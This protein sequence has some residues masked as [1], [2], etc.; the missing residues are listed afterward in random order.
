METGGGMPGK[1]IQDVVNAG[2]E[3]K[4]LD[5]LLAEEGQVDDAKTGGIFTLHGN[6]LIACRRVV[7]AAAIAGILELQ[8]GKDFVSYQRHGEVQFEEIVGRIRHIPARRIIPG[9]LKRIA[10]PAANAAGPECFQGQFHAFGLRV[11]VGEAPAV[12]DDQIVHLVVE[13]GEGSSQMPPDVLDRK[14][15]RLNSSHANISYA[16]FC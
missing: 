14:S 1:A 7:E 10:R 16:V 4:V 11:K 6:G 15:T 5:K 8:A 9:V 13:A 3:L 12:K 2:W